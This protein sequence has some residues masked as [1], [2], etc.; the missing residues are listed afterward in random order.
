M[1]QP[2]ALILA[3][4]GDVGALALAS[5]LRRRGACRVVLRDELAF[6]RGAVV[7]VPEAG[8]GAPAD[9]VGADR[10][11]DAHEADVIVCRAHAFV[12]RRFARPGDEEYAAAELHAFALSWLWARRE[13]LLNLP[14]PNSL[15][16]TW[17]DLLTLARLGA[18]VGLETP[19]LRFAT[20]ASR[21]RSA[22]LGA[23]EPGGAQRYE[24]GSGSV[25]VGVDDLPMADGPPLASP[26]VW[27]EPIGQ[28][29]TVLVCGDDVVGAPA[30]LEGR[31]RALARAAGLGVAQVG[32]AVPAEG[33]ARQMV[34][35][36]SPVPALRARAHVEV[37]AAHLERRAQQAPG[38]EEDSVA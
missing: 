27:V 26:A 30:A 12:P 25:P 36:L 2:S 21:T 38:R 16:G 23:G 14:T 34:V 17:P 9:E 4:R 8:P 11:S 7:H 28:R 15:P 24:W 29:S 1:P 10:L 18:D 22:G 32:L 6:S 20:H 3:H 13:R 5:E 19:R 37:T 31:L 33:A 35:S